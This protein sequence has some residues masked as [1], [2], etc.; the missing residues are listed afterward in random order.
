VTMGERMVVQLS[1][2]DDWDRVEPVREAV[3]RCVRATYASEE[4]SDALSMVAA[5]LLENAVKYG[6][7]GATINFALD[8]RDGPTV[9]VSNTVEDHSPH[10]E[11]L[12]RRIEWVSSFADPEEAYLQTMTRVYQSGNLVEGS[13]S[14]GIL[15]I[16]HEG[17]CAIS[18][19]LP[20]P[21]TVTV[22][23]RYRE[24]K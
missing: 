19:E 23:A 14:L 13:S 16:A 5:E 12:R 7:G 11:K 18:C 21:R 10:P 24:P 8:D 17:H 22:K 4:M 2:E 1:V 20:D 9:S 3:A 6:S 15:R